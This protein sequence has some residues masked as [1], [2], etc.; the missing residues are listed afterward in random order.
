MKKDI[1]VLIKIRRGQETDRA[2]IMATW[3][4]G[5]YFGNFW[6]KDISKN[7]FMKNYHPIITEILA[8]KHTTVDVAVLKDDEEI[9]IGYSIL[10]HLY[11]NPTLHWV[12]VKTPWR[13]L[14]I[15]RRL[16]PENS[17]TATHMTTLGWKIKPE[18]MKFNPYKAF[19][20]E[21]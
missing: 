6:F 12:H 8:S 20:E 9:I 2:F 3:L 7:A 13:K 11:P 1:D 15:A 14:G 21:E 5:F 10:G 19:F 18:T 4:R 16:V 17:D